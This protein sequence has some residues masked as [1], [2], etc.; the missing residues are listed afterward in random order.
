MSRDEATLEAFAD[1]ATGTGGICQRVANSKKV[2]D[3][4]AEMVTAEFRSLEFDAAVLE[5]VHRLKTLDTEQI[6]EAIGGTRLQVVA[7]V[8]RLGR[9]DFLSDFLHTVV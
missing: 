3:L 4:I 5:Q 9:R 1:I 8:A 2:I 6:A 7:A